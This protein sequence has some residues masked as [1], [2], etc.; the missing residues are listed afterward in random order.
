MSKT[1]ERTWYEV[2]AYIVLLGWFTFDH[3]FKSIAEADEFSSHCDSRTRT[4]KVT[5]TITE[6]RE[7]LK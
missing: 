2:E 1:T 6:T 3:K 4:V 7:V 5:E